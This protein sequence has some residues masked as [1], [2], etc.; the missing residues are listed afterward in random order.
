MIDIFFILQ[1]TQQSYHLKKNGGSAF[2]LTTTLYFIRTPSSKYEGTNTGRQQVSCA[3]Q[4]AFLSDYG[5]FLNHF[6]TVCSS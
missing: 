2:V 4:F 5:M 1:A 6:N 3:T